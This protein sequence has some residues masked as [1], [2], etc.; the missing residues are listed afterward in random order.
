MRVIETGAEALRRMFAGVIE[1]T[2]QTELGVADPA[3]TDYLS[4]LLLRFTKCEAIY[5]FHDVEGKRLEEVAEMLM[6]AEQRQASPKRELHRHIG[7]YTLFW[8]GVF[9]ESLRRMQAATRK[10]HLIDYC[11]Q[12][13]RSY[14]I[15]STFDGDPYRGEAP[16]LRRLSEDFELCREGLNRARREWASQSGPNESTRSFERN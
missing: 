3:L 1:Q 14:F 6:E 2:F 10:D 11:E 8:S 5:R 15:A 4:T 12:G 13:R 7:D 9:P 16:I